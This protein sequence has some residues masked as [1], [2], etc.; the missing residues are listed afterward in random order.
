MGGAVNC[1]SGFS[2]KL[3]ENLA[4]EAAPAVGRDSACGRG[5]SPDWAATGISHPARLKKTVAP[6]VVNYRIVVKSSGFGSATGTPLAS[7]APAAHSAVRSAG[8]A[9]SM[10][11]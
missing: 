3:L 2:R 8:I 4:A 10:K 5:F 7:Q 9:C 1:G 11:W 6:T